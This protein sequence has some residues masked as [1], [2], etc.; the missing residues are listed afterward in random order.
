MISYLRER[1]EPALRPARD[2][3]RT[4]PALAALLATEAEPVFLELL[5]I[6]FCSL[7]VALTRP[8]EGWLLRSSRRCAEVGLPDLSR[9]LRCHAR[10]EAGHDQMM[11]R[12]THA[13]VARWN[14]RRRPSF[15][16][17]SLLNRAPTAGG[18]M[19]RQLHEDTIAGSTPFAQIAI[20]YE[21][22]MLPVQFGPVLLERCRAVLGPGITEGLSFLHE[23]IT[24]DVGHTRFNEQ[25]LEKLLQA[26]PEYLEALVR[27]GTAA[28]AAYQAFLGDCIAAARAQRAE[29]RC[30]ARGHLQPCT[31]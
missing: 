8:V 3:F 14:A 18:R 4:N 17:E 25:Q 11:V 7:G 31:H 26:H 30:E 12:D 20:E 9:A 5:L 23:H 1:Y 6:Q 2:R 28:L 22:E 15:D 13:L 24:L 21:I 10:A 19:Y 16:A 27:A 29:L